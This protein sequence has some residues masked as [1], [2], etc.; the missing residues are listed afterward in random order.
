FER[1]DL[2]YETSEW[3]NQWYVHSVYQDG[4][5]ND[6]FVTG[7]WG[8]DQRVFNNDVVARS[9]MIRLG[10]DATF[11]GL[12]ELRYRTLQNENY[13]PYHYDRYHEFTLGYSRPVKGMIVGGEFAT[14]RDS[15]GA[16]FSRI[17]GFIRYDEQGGGLGAALGDA[18][19]G[20]PA[21]ERPGEIFVSG[22]VHRYRVT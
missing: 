4:M 14:G 11:G 16:S 2:T 1:F 17:A 21:E 9:N 19:S 20:G 6:G 13:G 18:L 22:G 15:F 3:Q 12:L 10:W 5:T 8:A 7:H